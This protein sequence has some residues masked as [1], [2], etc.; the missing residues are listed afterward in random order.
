MVGAKQRRCSGSTRKNL[1]CKLD[2]LPGKERCGFHLE[3]AGGA[4][5][6]LGWIER[7]WKLSSFLFTAILSLIGYF[8]QDRFLGAF[9]INYLNYAGL[10]DVSLSPNQKRRH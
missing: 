1:P 4:Q 9:D 8:Y 7:H 3:Q 5:N 6:L 2:A 10:D